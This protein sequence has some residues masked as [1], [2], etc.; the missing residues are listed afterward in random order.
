MLHPL[1]FDMLVLLSN[2][3]HASL[4]FAAATNAQ[5]KLRSSTATGKVADGRCHSFSSSNCHR[6]I[7][8]YHVSDLFEK[9]SFKNRHTAIREQGKY[10]LKSW[11]CLT[12]LQ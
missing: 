9:L 12:L 5:N 7:T 8:L 3:R 4:G 11:T 10:P 6:V 1:S 2:F